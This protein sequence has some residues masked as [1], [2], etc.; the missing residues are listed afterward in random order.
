ML[1]GYSCNTTALTSDFRRVI[2]GLCKSKSACKT[3]ERYLYYSV[4]KDDFNIKGMVIL[5][6]QLYD[7]YVLKHLQ[8]HNFQNIKELHSYINDYFFLRFEN[9]YMI[10]EKYYRLSVIDVY[11][12]EVRLQEIDQYGELILDE[13]GKVYKLKMNIDKFEENAEVFEPIVL[14]K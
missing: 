11:R 10:Q 8:K 1:K 12:Y 5:E 4:Y 2:L 14:K 7:D 3:L 6:K 9:Y 13:N